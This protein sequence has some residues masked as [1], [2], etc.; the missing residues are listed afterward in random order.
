MMRQPGAEVG[1]TDRAGRHWIRRA[2]GALESIPTNAVDYY[3]ISRPITLE[4]PSPG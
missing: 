4:T 3:G 1:F 2:T